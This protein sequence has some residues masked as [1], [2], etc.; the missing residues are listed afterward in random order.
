MPSIT[1]SK[2][3]TYLYK[4]NIPAMDYHCLLFLRRR[5]SSLV[6]LRSPFYQPWSLQSSFFLFS[7][8]IVFLRPRVHSVWPFHLLKWTNAHKLNH[9]YLT[10]IHEVGPGKI[11][12]NFPLTCMYCHIYNN[13]MYNNNWRSS[14][15]PPADYHTL[16]NQTGVAVSCCS[17]ITKD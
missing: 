3:V 15:A 9:V 6:S 16:L 13:W 12:A 7:Q 8:A 1:A 11:M 5:R 10:Y 17:A 2:S 4:H 14:A